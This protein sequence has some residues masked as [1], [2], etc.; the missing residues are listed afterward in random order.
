MTPPLIEIND[1][2]ISFS[3]RAGDIEA[4]RNFS[5][6]VESG[7]T[8]GLVGESGC[9]KSTVALGIMGDLGRSGRITN[10]SIRFDGR[11][12]A[13]LTPAEL[14]DMRGNII[15]MVYQEPMA[16]LNPVMKIAQQLIEIPITHERISRRKALQ[17]ARDIL[18]AVH[19][20]DPDRILTS[21]PHQLS[22]GQQQRIVIAMALLSRPKL[23][24]LDEPTT[25]LDVTIEAGIIDLIKK[26][27]HDFGT[28]MMFIS[29]NLG[30]IAEICHRITVMYAG[31]VIETAPVKA[32]FAQ[33]RHP[34]TQ[35]LLRSIP[36]PD[37]DKITRPL[38]PIPGQL[39]LPNERPFGCTFAPRC[40]FFQPGQCDH[41]ATVP[42]IAVDPDATRYARCIRLQDIDFNDLPQTPPQSDAVAIGDTILTVVDLQ[43]HYI[44]GSNALFTNKKSM[45]AVR[46]NQSLSFS[47]REGETM[48]IVGESG[49]GKSTL[50]RVLLGLETAT[51]G[52]AMLDQNDIANIP[53]QQRSSALVRDV[54]MVFQN[55]FDTL[56]PSYPVGEQILRCLEKFNPGQQLEAYRSQVLELLDLVKL[57]HAFEKRMPRQLSGGQ[58]QRVG[59][60]RAFAGQPRMVI[61]D[62]PVSALDVSVQAAVIDLLIQI[63][64]RHKTLLVLISHDL[65]VVRYLA[66]SIVVMYL[67]L[68][69]EQGSRDEV[70][71]P[72]YHPYTEALLSA[73]P[74]A[75]P[76]LE[77]R[78]IVL[79]GEIP[80]ALAPPSGC[81][82]H[83][84]CPYHIE[85]VCDRQSPPIRTFGDQH[86]IACHLDEATLMAMEPVIRF[87]DQSAPAAER[88]HAPQD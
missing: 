22:G 44:V 70:V 46:A 32:I 80:S 23:L 53:I 78:R 21:Y 84:R 59:I 24:L 72:P 7:E 15:A 14:R 26:L 85:G 50:A 9:G 45:R 11:D 61:A 1:L 60:A 76:A 10:G 86:R 18:D 83:T 25:A 73:A 35:G 55:P 38:T 77:K 65:S 8:M 41:N 69:M 39:P 56:N 33:P 63:Q 47:A 87:G 54:Q 52:S 57:P 3:T 66:D 6:N 37:S 12:M 28:A 34:Y 16:T 42:L 51:G 5:C 64:R 43:K 17:R 13:T 36:R 4:V 48:A 58:K 19:I 30:L 67:G 79:E 31:E 71:N 49:C 62:E 74:I 81:P 2:S 27:A 82:F 29:H 88:S 75:D 20:P 68:I 40:A